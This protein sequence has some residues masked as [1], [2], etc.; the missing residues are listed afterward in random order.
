MCQL[1]PGWLNL[2]LSPACYAPTDQIHLNS[3][4][5]HFVVEEIQKFLAEAGA[6]SAR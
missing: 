5:A 3:V 2:F 1:S 4:G 6:T